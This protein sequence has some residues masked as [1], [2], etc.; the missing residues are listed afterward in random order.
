MRRA[1]RRHAPFGGRGAVFFSFSKR[2]RCDERRV[3]AAEMRASK[4]PGHALAPLPH[5]ERWK[6]PIDKK[7]DEP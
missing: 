1:H 7:S 4:D 2:K 5:A 3:P 6:D